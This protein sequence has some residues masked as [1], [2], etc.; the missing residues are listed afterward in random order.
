MK[1]A[2]N[3]V[4]G[5]LGFVFIAFSLM[6]LLKLVPMPPPPEGTPAAL[7]VGAFVPTGYLTFV[8][9]FELIG[10]CLIAVP[11]T[12]NLG[13]LVLGPIILNIL[14]FHTFIMK[15]EGLFGIPVIIG[16]LALF[17]LWAGRKSFAG[18]MN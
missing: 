1:I 10:G 2:A 16:V 11:R 15:G 18:L 3:I 9:V 4:G 17:L 6:V 13:L 8:K 14:A 5:L 12:R 7:F